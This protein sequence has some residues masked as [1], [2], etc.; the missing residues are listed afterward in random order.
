MGEFTSQIR[1]ALPKGL[2]PESP[3][4]KM[5]H[6]STLDPGAFWGRFL[7]ALEAEASILVSNPNWPTDW[8]AHAETV[9]REFERGKRGG[10]LFP[11]SGSTGKPVFCVHDLG[12]LGCAA[13][14]FMK[15]FGGAG[16]PNAL[17]VLPPYHV[18]GI[19]P[20]L[21]S[22]RLGGQVHF[23]HYMDAGS[24][25]STP[26]PLESCSISVVPTQ[27]QRMVNNP[28]IL[29]TLRRVGTVFIG[30]AA[31][32][33]KLLDEARRE[34]LK[35]A[36]CYGSTETA[37][38]VTA[39][40]PED[41]LAGKTGVGSPMPHAVLEVDSEN[42]I[43]VRTG[44]LMR[45]SLPGTREPPENPFKTGDLGHLDNEG[46]LHIHGRSDRVIITGGENVHPE[47]IELA[48]LSSGFVSRA[49]CRA[50]PD[51][52]WGQR[53]ELDVVLP[54]G[55]HRLSELQKILAEKLPPYA[56]P[57]KLHPVDVL[58]ASKTFD[59]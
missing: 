30:G 31:C 58:P 1:E 14:G 26:F 8:L 16:I 17:N 2:L 25:A 23:A 45:E 29:T 10:I 33:P 40:D 54:E 4:G 9:A 11:T 50:L 53:I 36:P 5:A 44:S 59:D 32:H 37:A 49:H 56:I 28:S 52:E 27:L 13:D 20:V 12:T 43:L 7:G 57:K 42:R 21:R 55:T 51:P 19:M 24:L 34:R 6:I 38:M 39:L 46:H 47:Q 41:F 22:A 15:Y 48:A 3:T 18:G 35:L